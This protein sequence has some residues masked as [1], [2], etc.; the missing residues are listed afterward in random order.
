MMQL[1]LWLCLALRF[2]LLINVYNVYSCCAYYTCL[3]SCKPCTQI[4]PMAA[5]WFRLRM[6]DKAK[7]ENTQRNNPCTDASTSPFSHSWQVDIAGTVGN[8]PFTA[9][10]MLIL[11]CGTKFSRSFRFWFWLPLVPSHLR[12]AQIAL[13]AFNK[14]IVAQAGR[15]FHLCKMLTTC[16]SK[17]C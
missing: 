9:V 1:H 16:F 15:I 13:L 6:D 7:Q 4:V 3:M 8:G 2:R 17:A 10:T 11:T 14:I 5:A 12:A